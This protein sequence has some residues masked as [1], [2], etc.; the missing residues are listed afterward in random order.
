M[1][2]GIDIID[3]FYI[4][5][6]ALI[7][8]VL[9]IV[10][11]IRSIQI[12]TVPFMFLMGLI[13]GGAVGNIIDRMTMGYVF[14][15]GGFLEGH[16][17]D[18]IHFT[19]RIGNTPV[20]PYIFN[21]A[22]IGISVAVVLFIV[23]NKKFIPPDIKSVDE[24]DSGDKSVPTGKAK[25]VGKG[26]TADYADTPGGVEEENTLE[27]VDSVAGTMNV[28]KVDDEVTTDQY[29][30]TKAKNVDSK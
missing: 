7:A 23:F 5:L 6:F 14:G 27:N 10:Y 29:S 9:I 25:A 21:V 24:V 22:D 17:V 3:T 12:A 15:Y 28:H 1:A 20:F 30:D 13:I 16:V 18:F 26:K 2:L 8:T 19:L 4:S 11:V